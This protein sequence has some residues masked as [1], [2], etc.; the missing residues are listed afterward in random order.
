MQYV[1]KN[2]FNLLTINLYHGKKMKV[3]K[4]PDPPLSPLESP[5]PGVGISHDV[6]YKMFFSIKLFRP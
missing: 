4:T 6:K 1:N 2:Q 5:S 3:W